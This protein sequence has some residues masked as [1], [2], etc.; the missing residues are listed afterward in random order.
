MLVGLVPSSRVKVPPVEG[1]FT[2]S[3]GLQNRDG[4]KCDALVISTAVEDTVPDV[5]F[6]LDMEQRL[7]QLQQLDGLDRKDQR[8]LHSL[9]AFIGS[10]QSLLDAL[11]E[12]ED[13]MQQLNWGQWS[14][15]RF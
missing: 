14:A 11:K 2:A 5:A 12:L 4:R 13:S 15:A 7:A 1:A 8:S 6:A 9:F 3:S 10:T